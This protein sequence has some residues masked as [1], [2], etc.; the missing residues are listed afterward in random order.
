M[1]S[2]KDKWE[3]LTGRSALVC[4]L[5]FPVSVWRYSCHALKCLGKIGLG[6]ESRNLCD[7]CHR[8]VGGI[9]RMLGFFYSFLQKI[10]NGGDPFVAF[11]SMYQ[12]VFVNVY[13]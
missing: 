12:I 8:I 7:L 6:R 5:Q 10:I 11:E 4:F 2:D 3:E 1:K 9:Q 13:Q